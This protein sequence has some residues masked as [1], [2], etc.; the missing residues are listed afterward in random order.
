MSKKLNYW[1]RVSDEVHS[2]TMITAD[3]AQHESFKKLKPAAQML[4][5]D[6]CL[7]K[8]TPEQRATLE[9]VLRDYNNI[10]NLNMS[11]E[12]I[13]AESHPNSRTRYSKGYFVAP[14]K[15]ICNLYG[16]KP[17]YYSKLM[18]VLIDNGFIRTAYGGKGKYNG[19]NENATI[20]QFISDWK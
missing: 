15:Q 7:H 6:L 11:E 17:S 9:S 1:C 16:W 10:Y 3:V 19:W 4:Y 18:D 13:Q 12:D 2:F 20:Y 14:Q 8:D 5:I